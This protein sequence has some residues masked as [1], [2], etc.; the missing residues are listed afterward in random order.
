MSYLVLARKYRPETFHDILGQ[1]HVT[2]TILNSFKKD[3]IAH[4]YLFCGPRG[5]GKTTTARVLA[6]ALNCIERNSG[7]PCNGCNNC[8]EI[9]SSRNMDVIEIDGA[10]NRGIDEIRNLRDLVKYSPMNSRYKIFIID[11][12]HM[13]T[14]AAFNALLKTLEEPP[15]HVKF[16]FATTESN[17]V[18]PTI[19]SRCQRYDFHRISV[20]TINECLN[21]IAKKENFSIEDEV[22]TLIGNNS[23]GSLRDAL[24]LTD[25]LLAFSG[26]NIT[27]KDAIE[28]LRIIPVDI[29]FKVSN[30]LLS[31]NRNSL[32]KILNQIYVSGYSLSDFIRG[33]NSHLL[34]LLISTIDEGEEI[35]D[36]TSDLKSQYKENS[37]KWNSRDIIRILDISSKMESEL[38]HI[39]QTK[40]YVEVMMLK[41]LE[42]D[43]SII[44]EDLIEKLSTTNIESNTS[45]DLK[46]TENIIDKKE[47][48]I[49]NLVNNNEESQKLKKKDGND[50]LV[51]D[52]EL[53]TSSV[54]YKNT[55]NLKK[56]TKKINPEAKIES[57]ADSIELLE[58]V[59]K[60]WKSL[61][62]KVSESGASIGTFLSSGKPIEV[63]GSKII[64]AFSKSNK[65]Q[66]EVL[67]KNSRKIEKSLNNILNKELR[68]DFVISEKKLSEDNKEK[69]LVTKKMLE[70]FGGELKFKDK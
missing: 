59:S 45:I 28:M 21:N 31:K 52:E 5:V 9:S 62:S 19:I 27:M 20:K 33:F 39:E 61:L 34:N 51:S 56:K 22:F 53:N 67:K 57:S 49:E 58:E 50:L 66:I 30:S 6:K 18:L 1:E 41:L 42:M 69:N 36:M 43:S 47:I 70:V 44:I 3:R 26:N 8:E 54:N 17:K 60:N 64:I 15:A 29:F 37:T 7:N 16:I 14:Q 25:Q 63:V 35:L 32:L 13:L 2:Q 4:A 55:D 68:V 23:D 24:S 38:K 40:V 48:V 46:K 12:V 10:S 11:E 65:F